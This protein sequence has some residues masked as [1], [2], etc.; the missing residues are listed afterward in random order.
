MFDGIFTPAFLQSACAQSQQSQNVIRLHIGDISQFDLSLEINY[1]GNVHATYIKNGVKQTAT[2]DENYLEF[3]PDANTDV[4]I[5]GD[6]TRFLA[7]APPNSSIVAIDATDCKSLMSLITSPVVETLKIGKYLTSLDVRGTNIKSIYYPANNNS[8]STAIANAIT[9]ADANN[10][11][12]YTDPN[13]TYYNTIANAATA[14]GW[15]I[16]EL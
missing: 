9:N 1:S 5:T 2:P 12:V 14:K 11:T 4:I 16:E 3:L 7:G 13:G 8:V 6:I 15:T 10:G